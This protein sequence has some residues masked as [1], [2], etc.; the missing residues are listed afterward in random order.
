MSPVAIEKARRARLALFGQRVDSRTKG[1][2][3]PLEQ[4]LRR[5]ARLVLEQQLR[6]GVHKAD[7]EEQLRQEIERLLRIFGLRQLTDAANSAERGSAVLIP[8]AAITD[9]LAMKQIHITGIMGETRAGVERLIRETLIAGQREEPE[10]T[11]AE[12]A[13]RLRAALAA[14][15]DQ[16]RPFVVSPER[17]A[18]IARTELVQAV[19]TGIVEGYRATGV[20]ELEWLAY[21]DG[22]SGDRHHERMNGQVVRLGEYFITPLGNRLRY[23]GDPTAP[24]KE[25]ANCRC[26][27]AP[28]RAA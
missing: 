23:P 2:V 15:Q 28:R 21:S 7:D 4:W 11:A 20:A 16:E 26:T 6:R 17:A 14:N 12:I 8:P 24:I 19:N 1:L 27:V 3:G 18:L 25:T 22:N 5:Y 10:P 9:F 13:R